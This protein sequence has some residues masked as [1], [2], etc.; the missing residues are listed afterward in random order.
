MKDIK[1]F[2][3]EASKKEYPYKKAETYGSLGKKWFEKCKDFAVAGSTNWTKYGINDF[4][5][6]LEDMEKE[7]EPPKDA[8]TCIA[9]WEMCKA[10]KEKNLDKFIEIAKDKHI[11]K[12]TYGAF[13]AETVYGSY[14]LD[15]YMLLKTYEY[16]LDGNLIIRNGIL[17]AIWRLDDTMEMWYN[18]F[19][20]EIHKLEK[21]VPGHK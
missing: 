6:F 12:F 7:F 10:L 2:I 1:E 9:R 19:I 11:E 18:I 3:I 16:I 20:D 4:Q 17:N 5:G 21:Q 8:K 14:F 13:M 15:T